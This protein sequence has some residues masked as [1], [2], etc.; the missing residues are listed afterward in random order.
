MLEK[1]CLLMKTFGWTPD[2]VRKRI[3][4]AEGWAYYFWALEREDT[5]FGEGPKRKSKGYIQQEM[6]RLKHG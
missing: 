3:T 1:R 4:G 2:F 6:E 5:L